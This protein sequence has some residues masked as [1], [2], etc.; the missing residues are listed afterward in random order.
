MSPGPENTGTTGVV[1]LGGIGLLL[2]RTLCQFVE[3]ATLQTQAFSAGR[4]LGTCCSPKELVL[5]RTSLVKREAEDDYR[6][7]APG[8]PLS[9]WRDFA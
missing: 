9:S 8:V 1:G 2:G 4:K 7:A 6:V 5:A 3:A